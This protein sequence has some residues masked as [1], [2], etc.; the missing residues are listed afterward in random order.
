M[1]SARLGYVVTTSAQV[2]ASPAL[3]QR[4]ACAA[5]SNEQDDVTTMGLPPFTCMVD[6]M[7]VAY[8]RHFLAGVLTATG[9]LVGD[10]P[11]A[12]SGATITTI[13]KRRNDLRMG[14]P[15]NIGFTSND[16][17]GRP[18]RTHPG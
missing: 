10:P 8:C 4:S 13:P 17:G 11:H 2:S 12:K 9:G 1:K 3:V 14:L 7:L 6:E 18:K 15:S 16:D 5:A